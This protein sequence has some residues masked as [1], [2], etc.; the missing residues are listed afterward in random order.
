[1]ADILSSK[2]HKLLNTLQMGL[3]FSKVTAP[4]NT[5]AKDRDQPTTE[6]ALYTEV[7]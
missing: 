1:M 6:I 7:G 3:F 5:Y 2:M 4:I